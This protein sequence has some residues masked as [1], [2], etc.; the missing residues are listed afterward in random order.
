MILSD[1]SIPPAVRRPSPAPGARRLFSHD[2]GGVLVVVMVIVA[3]VLL[4]GVALFALGAGETDIVEYR[5]DSTNA[6]WLAEGGLERARGWLSG[7]YEDNPLVNPVGMGAEDQSLHTGQYSFTVTDMSAGLGGLPEFTVLATGSDDGAVRQVRAVMTPETFSHYQWFVDSQAP[8]TWFVTGDYFEGP[9]HMNG[10]LRVDGDPWFGARV[11]AAG[12]YIEAPNS[13]PTFTAGYQINVAPI[14]LPDYSQIN[15]TLRA[16]AIDHGL[17][18]AQLGGNSSRYEV[19]LGRNGNL[20]TLSY[21]SYRN[22]YSNWTDVSISDLDGAAWFESPLWIEGTID[23]DLTIGCA[24]EIW[25]TNDVLFA[26]STPGEGPDPGCDDILGLVALEDIYVKN[27]VPNATDCEIHGI[28]MSL[29]RRFQV[30]DWNNPPARGTLTTWGGVIADQAWRVGTYV[31]GVAR[32][33][34]DRE[35]HYDPRMLRMFPPFFPLTGSMMVISWEEV[36]P[37]EV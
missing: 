36:I 2:H 29:D 15:Q 25:I 31:Q 30:E 4:V 9:V 34:Y 24:E 32:S 3:A 20:G 37:P 7:I 18:A 12:S 35:W 28:L 5:A 26:D 13:N 17:Y 19:V 27:T 1:S 11:T 33:G 6:L 8:D 10:H 22:G 21:R 23:G 16:A 14:P